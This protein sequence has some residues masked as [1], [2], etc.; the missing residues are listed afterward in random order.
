MVKKK[1]ETCM[2]KVEDLHGYSFTKC[3]IRQMVGIF[4]NKIEF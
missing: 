3:I 4:S 2:L 1:E